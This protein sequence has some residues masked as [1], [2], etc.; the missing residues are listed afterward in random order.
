VRFTARTADGR[1]VDS[2]SSAQGDA[3]FIVGEEPPRVPGLDAAVTG[4]ALGGKATKTVPAAFGPRSDADV[5][6]VPGAM[7]PPGLEVGDTVRMGDGRP[8]LITAV[9]SSEIVVDV[10]H[11]MAG[12]DVVLDVEV[13]AHTPA[14]KLQYFVGGLGCFWGPELAF[15]RVPGVMSTAVGYANGS[16]KEPSYESVCSG[17]TGHAEVVRIAFDPA[18]VTFDDLLAVFWKKHDPT[19][20]NRQGGDVG[21]QY[22]SCILAADDAQLAAARASA[23][24][25]ASRRGVKAL[26]TEIAP[27][28]CYYRAEDYHQQYLAKGGRNGNAQSPAKLCNDPIRC[29]ACFRN[30]FRSSLAR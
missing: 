24:K 18:V 10:N 9:S 30:G 3:F 7:A 8:G 28:S 4:L 2:S 29:C 13:V 14:D 19:Q 6:R 22:R 16:T 23:E 12:Q 17:A 15:A 5:I 25:E 27:L 21:T 26:A 11:P 1:E 20:L